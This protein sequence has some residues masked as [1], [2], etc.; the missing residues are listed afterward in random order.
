MCLQVHALDEALG[1]FFAALTGAGWTM[2]S[3]SPPIMA[4]PTSPNGCA[5]SIPKRGG[6]HEKTLSSNT[7]G[8]SIAAALGLPENPLVGEGDIHL[9][10][11]LDPTAHAR[12]LRMAVDAYRASPFVAA[13]FTRSELEASPVPS[14]NPAAWSLK[15][16]A[17]A[18]YDAERSGDLLVLLKRHVVP[19]PKPS[20]F[21]AA[22]HGSAWDD[23]RRVP[24]LFW[25]RGMTPRTIDV[26]ADTVDI[27]PTL[28]AMLGLPLAPGSVDGTCLAGVAG[29][30][31]Q[32]R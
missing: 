26:P 23:D 4:A 5:A 3:C 8:R 30:L 31:C 18:S 19:I 1:R 7:I 24:I 11:D 2:W 16:R 21:T 27:M 10:P 29:A 9:A 12:V 15:Q 17:R 22:T 6:L 13:V 25:R 20:E 14:G 32:A 28:A